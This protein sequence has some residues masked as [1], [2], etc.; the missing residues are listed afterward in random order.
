VR[1]RVARVGLGI[2]ERPD[3][4]LR[5]DARVRHFSVRQTARRHA[6][7]AVRPSPAR[8]DAPEP[9]AWIPILDLDLLAALGSQIDPVL[10][11]ELEGLERAFLEPPAPDPVLPTAVGPAEPAEPGETLAPEPAPDTEAARLGP[12]PD[13]GRTHHRFLHW[14]ILVVALAVVAAGVPYFLQSPAQRRVTLDVDGASFARTTRVADVG[15]LLTAAGIAVEPGDRVIPSVGATLH[16]GATVRVVRAIPLTVDVDGSVRPV[17]TTARTI[18]RLRRELGIPAAL[19]A[20]GAERRLRR[21]D[22]VVFRTPSDL[23]L[24]TDGV[25]GSLTSTARTVGELLTERGVKF[26][27]GDQIDPALDTPLTSGLTVTVTH[28]TA[29]RVT[30]DTPVPFTVEER[31]DGSL[32]AGVR[33]VVQPGVAGIDR[34]TYQLTRD[35]DVVVEKLPLGTVRVQQPQPEITAVGT[36]PIGGSFA[37][38]GIATWYATLYQPGT[39]AHL[40]LPFG[41]IVRVTDTETGAATTCRVADR[42][43]EAWTG[44]IIDLSPDVFEQLRPLSTGEIH[45]RIDH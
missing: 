38:T 14:V 17:R 30:E 45:V 35:G 37:Q 3:A 20:V 26:A 27:A 5:R 24:V 36:Q 11:R 10:L 25:A 34:T 22:T 12:D 44:N 28:T 1:H 7:S 6:I 9:D 41:T 21:G 31:P 15:S 29:G 13:A 18:A 42:G 23:T 4:P 2:A 39:C 40:T 16:D 8:V 33:R 43:P 32:P 19:V